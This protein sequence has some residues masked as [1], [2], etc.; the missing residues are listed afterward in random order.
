M[1]MRVDG[2]RGIGTHSQ[3]AR[4]GL[5]GC[6]AAS[7]RFGAGVFVTQEKDCPG[8]GCGIPGHPTPRS[9]L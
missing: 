6:M 9:I 7:N 1:P 2:G 3:Q 4:G 5:G 8:E